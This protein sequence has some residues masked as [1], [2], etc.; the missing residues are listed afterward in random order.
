MQKLRSPLGSGRRVEVWGDVW[1][2]VEREH[3][4]QCAVVT[5]RGVGEENLGSTLRVISPFETLKP[6]R[7]P[8][9]MRRAKRH[10]VFR[11]AAHVA[12]GAHG[13]RPARPAAASA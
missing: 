13:L 7:A 11:S 3:F 5:L 9:R 1:L 4:E 6:L 12:A 10:T 2:V 8:A